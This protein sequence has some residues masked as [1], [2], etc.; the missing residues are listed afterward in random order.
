MISGSLGE[1]LYTDAASAS[2]DAGGADDSAAG[3]APGCGEQ[4]DE[5]IIDADF[6]VKDETGEEADKAEASEEAKD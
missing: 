4:A 1:M 2:Q 6:E 3:A 5:D